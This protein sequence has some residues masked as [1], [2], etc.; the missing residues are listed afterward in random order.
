LLF[1][2]PIITLF[3]CFQIIAYYYPDFY[4]IPFID[5]KASVSQIG[6]GEKTIRI[7]KLGFLLYIFISIFFYFKISSFFF[8]NGIK[9]KFKICAVLANFFLYVYI[10]AL[11]RDGSLYEI[12]RRL[13]ITFYIANIYINHIYL[14]KILK[15][16]KS[17]R[18]VHF[19]TIY[20]T[21]FYIIIILMTILIII[22]LPWVNPLFKYPS[23]LKNIIEWNYFL[24]TIVFYLPLSSMFYQLNKRIK[25]L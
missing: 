2:V 17:K 13:A 22:G 12:S 23:E 3:V 1:L 8:L 16:L 7:F 11:G 14:I 4:T 21:I 5:G 18:K 24:L 15:L 20:L 19:N 25:K 6:R 10:I 9:N